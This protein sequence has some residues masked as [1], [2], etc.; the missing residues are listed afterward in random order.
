M[1]TVQDLIC[2]QDYN[3]NSQKLQVLM[4]LEPC[5][6]PR[7]CAHESG[8]VRLP[9]QTGTDRPT[10]HTGSNLSAPVWLRYPYQ[11]GTN[12][13]NGA[14]WLRSI[15]PPCEPTDRIQKKVKIG[16]EANFVYKRCLSTFLYFSSWLRGMS[17]SNM[18]LSVIGSTWI[19]SR[20]HAGKF[21]IRSKKERS[22]TDPLSCAQ[23]LKLFLHFRDSELQCSCTL[24][25]CMKK[26]VP[27][28]G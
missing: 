26:C 21:W 8:S 11:R 28:C 6:T 4:K 1:L 10:V 14:V 9:S 24:Y 7:P 20:V 25:S 13:K 18:Y 17:T 12:K 5:I 22:R 27:S 23:G 16:N 2:K 3:S 19:L 15:W